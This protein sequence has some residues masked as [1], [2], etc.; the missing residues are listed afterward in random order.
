MSANL[1]PHSTNEERFKALLTATSDVVYSLSPDWSVMYELDGRGFLKDASAPTPDWKTTNVFSGDMEMV[2]EK[3][4]D[5]IATK[6]VFELEHRVNRADGTVGWTFSRAV[7]ILDENGDIKEWFGLAS[8]ITE[9]KLAEQALTVAKGFLEQQRKTYEI[10]T[11][12]SPDLMYMFDLDYKFT[13]ANRALL[14]MWGKTWEEAI[15]KG[16]IENGYE[17]WHADMHER[18]IDS[19]RETGKSIRG[20]VAFPHATLGRRLYDYILNPVFNDNGEVIA[21]S[22]TTRDVTDRDQWQQKLK[23]SAEH[24]QAMN[25]EFAAINEELSASNE[26]IQATNNHLSRAN[27]ELIL[28]KQAIEE[29]KLALRLA[30]EAANFG[31][32]YIHS[33]TRAFI[34]DV[35]LK[36]LFGYYPDESLSIEQ[37]LAQITDDYR[38]FVSSKLENAIYNNGD[39]D[40]SYPVIGLHD[41]KLRW[42]RA[43]GNLMADSSGSFSAFTGVMMD[44]TEQK[45]EEM[46]KNDFMGMVSHELKTPLTSLTA[47]LQLMDMR[48]VQNPDE[49]SRRAVSQ[50]LKQAK[51]MTDMINGFLDFSRL[52]SAKISIIRSDFDIAI[53]IREAQE[54]A[55]MLYGTHKFIFEPVESQII[56]ADKGKMAQVISNLIGNAVKYSPSGSVIQVACVTTDG[57]VK[58]SIKDQGIGIEKSE[59]PKIFDRFYRVEGNHLISG[60]GIGLYVSSEIIKLHGGAIWVDSAAG[61][62]SVFS[63]TIPVK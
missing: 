35:R 47:Y 26:Q 33:V 53:L 28:A 4:A 32:W 12:G 30:I 52:E 58:V 38:E 57:A 34:T 40:V 13:Y 9:R 43:I 20:E 17:P 63:F 24:L 51:R 3:I 39:F 2:N 1:T 56:N 59:I 54:E 36:E 10:I 46:R 16:L 60:F 18:E 31:T 15:G 8:D 44:I 42:L 41:N 50:S 55:N 14:E 45:M 48:A 7:P 27:A 49:L 21:V 22:G 62:G 23:Q 5:A 61:K 37:A 19:I 6:S 29:G 11:S 25:E